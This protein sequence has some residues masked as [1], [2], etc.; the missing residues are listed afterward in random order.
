MIPTA[1]R[2]SNAK[3]NSSQR[4]IIPTSPGYTAW[5]NSDRITGIVME[6]IEGET[7]ADV[8]AR[9]PLA[10]TDALPIARQI[11]DALDAAHEKG[12]IHRD[13]KPANIA[14]TRDR[15][16]KV[17]DF[18]L[19]KATEAATATSFDVTH[20]PT[21]TPPAMMTGVGVILGT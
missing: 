18:G 19:A 3:R 2:V 17:L 6:L 5:R 15:S 7:L 9:G 10:L 21:L 11:A 20:S 14:L 4:S 13:L 16:V 1:W 12:I 8:I